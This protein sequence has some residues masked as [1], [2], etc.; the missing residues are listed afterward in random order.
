MN[1]AYPKD[2]SDWTSE[3]RD[4]F[5]AE[6]MRDCLEAKNANGNGNGA[7]HS[8]R[9][10]SSPS[11]HISWGD[12]KMDRKGLTQEIRKSGGDKTEKV[13]LSAAFEILGACRDPQGSSWGKFPRWL[14]D[15][16]RVHQRHISDA[17][18]QGDAGALCAALAGDGL[19]VNRDKQRA[20]AT[21]LSGAIVE[22][23]VTLVSRTGWHEVNGQQVFVLGTE[24]IGPVGSET[25][26]LDA[27]AVGKY[28]IARDA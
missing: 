10:E 18:L 9:A 6:E 16:R 5:F 26:I 2:F 1:R 13:W 17:A 14:D 27:A 12:F 25:V 4:A 3:A 19:K 8:I 22:E 20:F 11:G 21:Y 23:C 24:T 28:E 7:D 15:D